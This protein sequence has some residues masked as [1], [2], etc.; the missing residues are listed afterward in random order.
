MNSSWFEFI[1]LAC[2]IYTDKHLFETIIPLFVHSTMLSWL[3]LMREYTKW[4]L[5]KLHT[6]MT[7]G[8]LVSEKHICCCW[9]QQLKKDGSPVHTA[10][11]VEKH[12]RKAQLLL[13][14]NTTIEKKWI[15]S[16]LRDES[17]QLA[18]ADGSRA[19][20]RR[21]SERRSRL[22][23]G[24]PYKGEAYQEEGSAREKELIRGNI[25]KKWY[26]DYNF[27]SSICV[28]LLFVYKVHFFIL[29]SHLK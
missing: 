8:L 10:V 19:A 5:L 3:Y 16:I 4:T 6:L 17:L 18:A 12:T 11:G 26:P 29:I 7:M 9:I 13:L 20:E 15:S 25:G 28:L 14:L 21:Q 23:C 22:V 2:K 27:I 1:S 24:Y